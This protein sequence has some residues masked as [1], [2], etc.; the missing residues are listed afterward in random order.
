MSK[1]IPISKTISYAVVMVCVLEALV[2]GYSFKSASPLPPEIRLYN[3]EANL[4]LV[5]PGSD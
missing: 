3:D 1:K 4:K 2:V 5:G